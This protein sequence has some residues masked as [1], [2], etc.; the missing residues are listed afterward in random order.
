[1]FRQSSFTDVYIKKMFCRFKGRVEHERGRKS[2]SLITL[3][4]RVL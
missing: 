1:M 4:V 3:L 2:G